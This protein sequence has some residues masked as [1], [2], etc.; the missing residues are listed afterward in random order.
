[1]RRREYNTKFYYTIYYYFFLKKKKL[2]KLKVQALTS[3]QAVDVRFT[4]FAH[5]PLHSLMFQ[6]LYPRVFIESSF[7]NSDIWLDLSRG[8]L[9][10]FNSNE[11]YKLAKR[12][13]VT[14]RML[15]TVVE[16]EF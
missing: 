5:L 2:N 9:K 7:E 13:N 4:T 15:V 10:C 3:F 1:M 14:H 8:S 6:V 11:S 16:L 12:P